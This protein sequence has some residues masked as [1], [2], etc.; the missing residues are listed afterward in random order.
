[1]IIRKPTAALVGIIVFAAALAS[2]TARGHG[3]KKH[4]PTGFT[5]LAGVQKAIVLYDELVS[6]G[7]LDESWEMSLKSVAITPR[8]KDG[9][10]ELVISF[11]RGEGNPNT[12]YIFFT[13]DG[14]YAGSN[15]SGD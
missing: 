11:T 4:G 3:G 15:F 8:T 7:K 1:M 9:K 14:K 2:G 12:V 5:H 13:M 10:E 6:K